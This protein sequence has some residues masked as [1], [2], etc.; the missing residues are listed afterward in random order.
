MLLLLGLYE[1]FMSH[2]FL[3]KIISTKKLSAEA[4]LWLKTLAGISSWTYN[5]IL[6]PFFTVI[7]PERYVETI[8]QKLTLWEAIV[9]L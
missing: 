9:Q 1:Q 7:K 8:N 3:W 4:E 2:F 5:I 6:L